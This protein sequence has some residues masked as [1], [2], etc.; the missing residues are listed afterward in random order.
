MQ[1]RGEERTLAWAVRSQL[2]GIRSVTVSAPGVLLEEWT[3]SDLQARLKAYP[4]P[5]LLASK[6][7]YDTDVY[8]YRV[9]S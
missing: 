8:V 9:L 1:L 4:C 7:T 5:H 6:R 3:P 2:S